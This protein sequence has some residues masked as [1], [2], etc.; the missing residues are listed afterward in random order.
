MQLIPR[1]IEPSRIIGVDNPDDGVR[2][3][4][5]MPPERS[6]LVLSAD[7]P[8]NLCIQDKSEEDMVKNDTTG[9]KSQDRARGAFEVC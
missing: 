5:V 3:L 1:L 8:D 6:D 9:S 4:V 2:V 7:V